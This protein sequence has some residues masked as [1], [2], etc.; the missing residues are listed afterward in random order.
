M[1]GGEDDRPPTPDEV[2]GMVWWNSLTEVERAHWLDVAG[3][4]VAADAWA[5]FK[6]S[7]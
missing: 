3:S 2:D 6:R 7:Q 1:T 4:A 5:A